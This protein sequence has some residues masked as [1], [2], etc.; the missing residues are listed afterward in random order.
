MFLSSFYHIEGSISNFINYDHDPRTNPAGGDTVYAQIAKIRPE[1]KDL[2][3]QHYDEFSLGYE[4]LIG[5]NFKIGLRGTYRSMRQIIEDAV[6]PSEGDFLYG[7]PGKGL[8]S[9]LP[10]VK[11]NYTALE[12][13]LEKSGSK[14]FNFL[15]SYVLS[16]NYGNYPGLFLADFGVGVA[17]PN[18]TNPFDFPELLINAT[19]LLPNDRTHVFKFSASYGWNF[20]LTSGISFSWQSGTPLSEIGGSQIPGYPGFIRQRGTAGRTP[21]LWDLNLRLVYDLSW[22]GRNSLK[23]H[24]ILDTFHIGSRRTPV[25]FDQIHYFNADENGNQ[26]NP[27][28]LYGRAT[29]FQPPMAVRMGLELGF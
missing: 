25:V 13:T 27:N 29:R 1:I 16:R 6:V 10:K 4:R 22:V 7:N 8:L 11:R 5:K 9:F 15:A 21:S 12:L 14:K 24:L 3:G 23:P 20:G 2:E 26:I 28:P 18:A 19:G 17:L